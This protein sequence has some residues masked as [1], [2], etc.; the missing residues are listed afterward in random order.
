MYLY[1]LYLFIFFTK[2]HNEITF[3][4]FKQSEIEFLNERVF[5][6]IS[7]SFSSNFDFYNNEASTKVYK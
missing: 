4:S 1:I 2:R 7:I 6:K 3:N 5:M